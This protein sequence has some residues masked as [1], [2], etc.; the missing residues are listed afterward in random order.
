M[1]MFAGIVQLVTGR[2]FLGSHLRIPGAGNRARRRVF[3]PTTT[4]RADFPDADTIILL[5]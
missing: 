4:T 5:C 3:S 2:S 1:R